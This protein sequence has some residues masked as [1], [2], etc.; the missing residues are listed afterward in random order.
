LV[1]DDLMRAIAR[2]ALLD[3]ALS[4]VKLTEVV[5]NS[6]CRLWEEGFP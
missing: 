6:I 5:T 1:S 2:L 3:E 4:F